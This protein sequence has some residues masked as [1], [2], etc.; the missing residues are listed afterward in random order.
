LIR[1][2]SLWRERDKLLRTG[3]GISNVLS[4]TL[5]AQMAEMGSL[6]SHP[7]PHWV[8][9]YLLSAPVENMH[10][11]R[12][13]NQ[14]CARPVKARRVCQRRSLQVLRRNRKN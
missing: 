2:N 5:L 13:L 12:P 6:K 1:N 9:S 4:G 10:A 14:G 7:S 11:R 3:S 8:L